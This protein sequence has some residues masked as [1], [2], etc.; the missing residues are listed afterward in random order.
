MSGIVDSFIRELLGE[1]GY[2]R[3][4][5]PIKSEYQKSLEEKGWEFVGND[6]LFSMMDQF[7]SLEQVWGEP[8]V[9]RIQSIKDRAKWKRDW[10]KAIYPDAE[11]V[12]FFR[13]YN[14]YGERSPNEHMSVG[15]YIKRRLS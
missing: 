14:I 7:E 15:V 12:R 8:M 5:N 10:Y 13:G 3:F 11:K 9:L 4:L 1:E 6:T 2:E